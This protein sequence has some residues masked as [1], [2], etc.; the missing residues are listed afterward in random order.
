MPFPRTRKNVPR[1]RVAPIV[2]FMLWNELVGDI[3]CILQPDG[4]YTIRPRRRSP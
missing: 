2:A 3:D 4:A 1:E